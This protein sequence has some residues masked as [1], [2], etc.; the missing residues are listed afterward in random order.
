MVL[1]PAQ[2]AYGRRTSTV[3]GVG[4]LE[5]VVAQGTE[6]A[7]VS[8]A[9]HGLL[10]RVGDTWVEACRFE[11]GATDLASTQDHVFVLFGRLQA[12]DDFE[13]AVGEVMLN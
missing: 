5:L 8:G 4:L 2:T 9:W 13:M 11:H 12:D 7:L 6:Y 10:E 3:L 1:E